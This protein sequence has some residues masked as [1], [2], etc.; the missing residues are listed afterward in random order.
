MKVLQRNPGGKDDVKA[1]HLLS[2]VQ[3]KLTEYK[4]SIGIYQDLLKDGPSEDEIADIMTNL[5]ACAANQVDAIESV[6][7][8]Q[9]GFNF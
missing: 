4:A 8:L 5:L 2:Q 3:Y 7:R 6:T 1:K 9:D